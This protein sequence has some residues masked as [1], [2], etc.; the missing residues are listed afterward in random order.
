[1]ASERD[2]AAKI[3]HFAATEVRAFTTPWARA[4]EVVLE[5]LAGLLEHSQD[6]AEERYHQ[7]HKDGYQLAYDD[8]KKEKP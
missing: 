6:Q 8:L 2:L 3:R 4:C 1:M 5:S 7:G